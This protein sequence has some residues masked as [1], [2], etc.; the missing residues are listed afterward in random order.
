M[1]VTRGQSILLPHAPH[2]KVWWYQAPMYNSAAT[3]PEPRP[4]PR[5]APPPLP[6]TE[7]SPSLPQSAPTNHGVRDRGDP[8]SSEEAFEKCNSE[9]TGKRHAGPWQCS[10]FTITSYAR[11]TSSSSSFQPMFPTGIRGGKY[12][13][14]LPNGGNNRKIRK[15]VNIFYRLRQELCKTLSE[16]ATS[17]ASGEIDDAKLRNKFLLRYKKANAESFKPGDY[18]TAMFPNGVPPPAGAPEDEAGAESMQAP[19]HSP[20]PIAA[21]MAQLVENRHIY[22]DAGPFQFQL[23][24]RGNEVGFFLAGHFIGTLC[25]FSDAT[26]GAGQMVHPRATTAVGPP[27]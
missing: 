15:I 10:L 12:Q 11:G 20:D 23:I 14:T 8:P 3:Q 19:I 13:P 25:R 21:W 1:V 18:D 24:M 22:I 17:L 6:R 27:L 9:I 26:R 16:I 7:P 2:P 4:H 5:V